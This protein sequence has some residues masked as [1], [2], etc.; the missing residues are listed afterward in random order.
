[1][2]TAT[3]LKRT[4]FE[5]SRLL[6]FFTEKE[7]QM[8]IGHPKEVWP[9]ALVKE[10]IDNS[11]DACETANVAPEI[12]VFVEKD[13][14]TVKDNGPGLPEKVLKRSLDY[15]V[16]VSDKNFYVSPT[17]G[18]LGN[19][20]K[21]VYAAPFVA[22]GERGL[23]EVMTRG[24]TYR[25]DIKLNHLVQEP[26]LAISQEAGFVKTGTLVKIHWPGVASYLAERRAVDSYNCYPSIKGIISSFACFNPHLTI[27][28]HGWPGDMEIEK[29]D[30]NWQK[31]KPDEPTSPH[32][33]NADR[34]KALIGAYLKTDIDNVR[35]RTV[36]EFVSE[37]RGLSGTAKQKAVTGSAGLSG[38]Y[39]ADLLDKDQ[40]RLDQVVSLLAA[41]QRES[42]AIK[43]M[44][45]GVVGEDHI[46]NHMVRHYQVQ[47]E[48]IKY[49]RALGVAKG[50]P[51]LWEFAF[52]IHKEDTE[53]ANVI[54]GLNWTPTLKNPIRELLKLLGENRVD[55]RDPVVLVVHLTC[56]VMPFLDRGKSVL[57]LIDDDDDDDGGEE[58]EGDA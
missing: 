11:L 30:P 2:S 50:L 54:V 27:R 17:R 28:L 8:Q 26:E 46:K 13:F 40:I 1:V 49:K 47:P 32:W 16:R 12:E 33:Y 29:A 18:Q 15:L 51:Y 56:P 20:L 52:G 22:D 38:A 6:E 14:I 25:V 21:C 43:P 23:I 9:I 45:L 39:L 7:L 19:A 37:F 36:R 42:R 58:E 3:T 55:S 48:S 57:S 41:M 34:L 4:T 44:A 5:Q 10:L 31:F 53:R 35:N 24:V